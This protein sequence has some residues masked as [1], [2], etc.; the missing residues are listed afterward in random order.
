MC[1]VRP[2]MISGVCTPRVF[3]TTT[4]AYESNVGGVNNSDVCPL[5]SNACVHHQD[6]P[7]YRECAFGLRRNFNTFWRALATMMFAVMDSSWDTLLYRAMRSYPTPGAAVV[8]FVMVYFLFMYGLFILFIAILLENFDTT[9]SEKENIQRAALRIRVM[10]VLKGQQMRQMLALHQRQDKQAWRR[11]I[12]ES[13]QTRTKERALRAKAL[14]KRS[15]M[16]RLARSSSFSQPLQS[17]NSDGR[18][19]TAMAVAHDV[20]AGGHKTLKRTGTRNLA[21]DSPQSPLERAHKKDGLSDSDSDEERRLEQ[22]S[23]LDVFEEALLLESTKKPIDVNQQDVTI[24]KL[25]HP[26]APNVRQP[27]AAV[28]VRYITRH[29]LQNGWWNLAL[30]ATIALSCLV[31]ALESPVEELA[32]VRPENMDKIDT[33]LFVVF[34]IEFVIKIFDHGIFWEHPEAYF[35]QAWNC[36]DFCILSCTVLDFVLASIFSGQ[37]LAA[38]GSVRVLRVLRPLRLINKIPSLQMLL[39]AIWAS[40]E[41]VFNVILLW[42]FT[43]LLFAILGV[44]LFAGGLSECN[45]SAAGTRPVMLSLSCTTLTEPPASW[46][47]PPNLMDTTNEGFMCDPSTSRRLAPPIFSRVQC[48]GTMLTSTLS[49]PGD[50]EA[51]SLV[52]KGDGT[53]ILAPRSWSRLPSNF[54]NFAAAIQAQIELISLENW[55]EIAFASADINGIGLQPR[56]NK[57]PVNFLFFFIFLLLSVFFILQLLVA[58]FI[59]AVRL[60]S[61]LSTY[62]DLQV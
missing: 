21:L 7:L 30:L 38:L 1:P 44:A 17:E 58:V 34:C 62:T 28:N 33:A 11:S 56:H 59:D 54:D 53:E 36:L 57:Q 35:R 55:S 48:A 16:N 45:D 31:L 41:D 29:I 47:Q 25:F 22:E 39:L 19:G 27:G 10:K 52:Y 4:E 37:N 24:F 61:G 42:A 51:V 40:R 13:Q 5:Y 8:F 50:S 32:V 60:Q 46:Y 43:F 15:S 49:R 6:C 3:P 20:E 9:D 12:I 18:H 26:P 14:E 23:A 2:T